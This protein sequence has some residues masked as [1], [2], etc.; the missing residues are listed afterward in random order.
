MSGVD[1]LRS[2][3]HSL[4]GFVAHDHNDGGGNGGYDACRQ[5]FGHPP[6]SL[7]CQQVPES[8]DDGG[9][10]FNLP[11]TQGCCYKG[12]YS[13]TFFLCKIRFAMPGFRPGV[14]NSGCGVEQPLQDFV[15]SK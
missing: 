8:L 15:E 1:Q 10:A 12:I 2:Q 14:G 6:E 5:P 13:C 4:E 11:P 9:P 7:L 3:A